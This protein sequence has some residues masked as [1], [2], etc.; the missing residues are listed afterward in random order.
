MCKVAHSP[1]PLP[2]DYPDSSRLHKSPRWHG[3]LQPT[4]GWIP[5]PFLHLQLMQTVAP[6]ATFVLDFSAGFAGNSMT[7]TN[8][9]AFMLRSPGDS[10]RPGSDGEKSTAHSAVVSV[11]QTQK[12]VWEFCL[13][14]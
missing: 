6:P 13:H 3:H 12:I 1:A 11:S 4:R 14:W 9:N 2:R 10:T 8:F 7:S 5:R